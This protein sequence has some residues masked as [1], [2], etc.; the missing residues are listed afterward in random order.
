LG[1]T[2]ATELTFRQP[3][4]PNKTPSDSDH[5]F[6]SARGLQAGFVRMSSV[7]AEL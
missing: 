3:A 1:N 2:L 4:D 7:M 5:F 6:S